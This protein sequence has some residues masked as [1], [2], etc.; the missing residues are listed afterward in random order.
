IDGEKIYVE[1]AS[2]PIRQQGEISTLVSIREI[3]KRRRAEK[4]LKESEERFRVIAEHSKSVI[5]ILNL[6]GK[7]FYVS[8]SAQE[9]FGHSASDFIGRPFIENIHP[10]DIRKVQK[11]LLQVTRTRETVEIELRHMHQEGYS[12]WLNSYFTPILTSEGQVE[13]IIV[14]SDDISESKKKESKLKKMAFYDYLTGLPNRRLFNERLE[15]AILTSEK[16]GNITALLVLDCDKFKRINDTLGHDVGDEVIKMFASRVKSVLRKK[17]TLSRVGG[18]EFTVVLPELDHISR[19]DAIC[20]RILAT[21]KEPM[22]INDEMIKITTSIGISIYPTTNDIDALY[23]EADQNL[24][25]SKEC[26]G[27]TYTK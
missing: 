9:I 14:I 26:G 27:N 23:K 16:T 15:Q 17:D 4:N 13:K 7:V 10:E 25:K 3:T 8:P 1:T 20:E 5:K 19:V 12:L 24:Y 18:D 11:I 6:T 2:V 22:F 21:V